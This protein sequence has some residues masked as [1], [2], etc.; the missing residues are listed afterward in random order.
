MDPD[1]P[2]EVTS[3]DGGWRVLFASLAQWPAAAEFFRY[4]PRHMR[5]LIPVLIATCILLAV[6][7]AESQ[8]TNQPLKFYLVTD[9]QGPG[10]LFVE[11]L[12]AEPKTGFIS[13]N[14][15]LV[16]T[17]IAEVRLVP[18]LHEAPPVAPRFLHIILRS[19]DVPAFTALSTRAA[20]RV[21]LI[22]LGNETLAA[23]RTSNSAPKVDKIVLH[24]APPD[25]KRILNEL[26]LLV[27]KS[28]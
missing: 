26:Q 18:S 2:N 10:K 17:N 12:P 28:G 27:Q 14:P 15:D 25:Q 6:S 23:P 4:P 19:E 11:N 7:K 8:G 22:K 13:S 9:L 5:N 21:L 1:T 16:L 3:A 24:I 20:G